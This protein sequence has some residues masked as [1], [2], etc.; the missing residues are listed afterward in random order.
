MREITTNGD[1]CLTDDNNL[2][3]KVP[4]FLIQSEKMNLL[5]INLDQIIV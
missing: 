2:I 3:Y 1:I 4:T 5:F